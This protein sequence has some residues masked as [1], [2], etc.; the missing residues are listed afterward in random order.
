MFALFGVM[1]QMSRIKCADNK[2]YVGCFSL[3]DDLIALHVEKLKYHL[4]LLIHL[5]S[6]IAELLFNT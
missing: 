6:L 5:T 3:K 1:H 2:R 4:Q